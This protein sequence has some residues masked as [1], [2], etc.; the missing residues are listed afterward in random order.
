MQRNRELFPKALV[1]L[2]QLSQRLLERHQ[3]VLH[4]FHR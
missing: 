2:L 1:F 4:L 3:R